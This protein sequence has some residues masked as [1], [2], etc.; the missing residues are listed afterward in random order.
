MTQEIAN[1]FEHKSPHLE[2]ILGNESMFL[3][4]LTGKEDEQ[5][6]VIRKSLSS[7]TDPAL[8]KIFLQSIIYV[9]SKEGESD[10]TDRRDAVLEVLKISSV[11]DLL[12][13]NGDP[14]FDSYLQALGSQT[15]DND[16]FAGSINSLLEAGVFMSPYFPQDDL[17]RKQLEHSIDQLA[18]H[19]FSDDERDHIKSFRDEMFERMTLKGSRDARVEYWRMKKIKK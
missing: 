6:R 11:V 9:L 19:F 15:K 3:T 12:S 10:E 14:V 7:L 17:S 2:E 16:P 5:E 1:P 13:Q 8:Q 18:K 4:M